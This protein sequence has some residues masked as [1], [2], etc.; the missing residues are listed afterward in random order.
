MNTSLT[1]DTIT[2]IITVHGMGEQRDNETLTPVASRLVDVI[3]DIDGT[4]SNPYPRNTLSLGQVTGQHQE[5]PDEDWAAFEGLTMDRLTSGD[6][7][8]IFNGCESRPHD[9][10]ECIRFSDIHWQDILQRH[11]L[12]VGEN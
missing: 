2:Y 4:A 11:W 5:Y 10:P 3:R 8:F 9:H 1:T 12:E 7:N 6:P